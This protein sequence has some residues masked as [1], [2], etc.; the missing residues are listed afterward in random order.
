MSQVKTPKAVL[1]VLLLIRNARSTRNSQRELLYAL[2]LRC[3]PDRQFLCFPS[4]G[5]LAKDTGL[6]VAT[7][8]RAAKALEQ[9]GIIRKVVR[10][11]RSCV[12]FLNI[13]LLMEQ[14]AAAKAAEDEA[15]QSSL[16]A[17]TSPFGDVN[18]TQDEENAADS[19]EAYDDQ[20]NNWM[21]QEA[22]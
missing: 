14:A 5:L 2:A 18:A 16:T 20:D 22:R 7:L 19:E 9:A 1:G 8:K 4:Y 10:P 17:F 6:D 21:P 15:K 13:K 3:N 12:F 11:N